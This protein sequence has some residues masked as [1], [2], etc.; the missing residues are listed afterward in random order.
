MTTGQERQGIIDSL[1]SS[2]IEREVPL[3]AIFELT[4][5][6]NSLCSFCYLAPSQEPE[7]DTSECLAAIDGLRSEGCLFLT[8]TGGE[9]LVR[10][11]FFDIAGHARAA[12]MALEIKS[13]ATLIGPCEAA[14]MRELSVMNV[15]V[16]L[17]ASTAAG[18]DALTMLPGS[19][20]RTLD[21]IAA[22][23]AEGVTVTAKCPLT[24]ENFEDRAAVKQLA[25]SL[26]C[27]CVFDLTV[28]ARQDGDAS[29]HRHKISQAQLERFIAENEEDYHASVIAC[30]T[31]GD[32]A[33]LKNERPCSAGV[34]TCSINPYGKVFPCIQLYYTMGDIRRNSFHEIW[35]D[36]PAAKVLRNVRFGDLRECG[37][38]PNIV[39]CLRCP[40][41]ALL[42]D[43]DMLG[44]STEACRQAEA[45]RRVKEQQDRLEAVS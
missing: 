10:P 16:S 20:R 9:P 22:L 25:V 12:G 29:A 41:L 38:C 4:Y 34:S 36:S 11:D 13:N 15:D 42:E 40:G 45:Y 1:I 28:T 21:G 43:G 7:L 39:H 37:A 17:H 31:A 35:R 33:E 24:R 5:K 26:G 32:L 18:H 23:R 27:D 44:R 19:W 6:C 2:S 8:L 3:R 30:L 14:R